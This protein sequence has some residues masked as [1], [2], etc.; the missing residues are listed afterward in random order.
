MSGFIL[1]THRIVLSGARTVFENATSPS[2]LIDNTYLILI[3]KFVN[4]IDWKPKALKQLLKLPQPAQKT[5]RDSVGDKLA[6][7]PQC[8][9]VKKLTSHAY[10]YRLRVG[11]Y[12]V[13]LSLTVR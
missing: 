11:N 6:V 9:G 10:S 5:I 2:L 7:F 8:E 13:F 3:T 4:T 1:E 12:R